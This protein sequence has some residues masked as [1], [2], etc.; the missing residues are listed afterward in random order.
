MNQKEKL[1]FEE[2]NKQCREAWAIFKNPMYRGAL[3]I[4]QNKHIL[5]MNYFKMPMTKALPWFVL[6]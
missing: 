1:Y 5:C 3:E 2:L 4:A 6:S